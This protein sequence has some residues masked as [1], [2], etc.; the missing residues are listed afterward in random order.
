MARELFE[1]L[2]IAT[3]GV[4]LSVVLIRFIG[5][6][7][8]KMIAIFQSAGFHNVA[9]VWQTSPSLLINLFYIACMLPAILSLILAVLRSQ[10]KTEQEVGIGFAPGEDEFTVQEFR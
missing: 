10:M 5:E 3:V 9:E 8:D 6:V 2:I 4:F 1:S 7:M